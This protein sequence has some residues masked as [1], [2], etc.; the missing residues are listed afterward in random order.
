MWKF[1]RNQYI[2]FVFILL[3]SFFQTGICSGAFTIDDEKKL[4]KEF[5]DKLVKHHLLL[6]NKRAN[7]Y[8]TKIGNL[9]LEGN[10]QVPFNFRF[11]IVNNSAINAFATPGGYIY[12]NKGLINAV[13]NEG[14]LAG[15]IAHEIAHANARHVASIIEKSQKLNIATL[16]AVLAGAFLGGGGEA[17]A[18]IATLSLAGAASL[19]LKYSREHEEEADRLGIEYLTSAGYYPAAMVDFLKIIKKYEFISKS[20]PSYLLTHPGTDERIFYLESLI[21]TQYRQGGLKNIIGNLGRIQALLI[22]DGDDLNTRYKQLKESTSKDPGNVDLLYALALVEDKLGKTTEALNSYQK[23]LS[24]APRDEDVLKSLGLIN[25]KMGKTEQA[26]DYL[27]RA[28]AS[29]PYNDEVILALGKAYDA[30]GK[31]DK[32]LDCFLKLENKI[33]DD[34]DIHYYI[35]MTYGKLN[36]LGESHYNFGLYF[37]NIKKKDT[38][39]FHFKKALDYF[40]E[41]SD[42]SANIKKTIDALK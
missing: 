7:E 6:E 14:E 40:P 26:R 36:I 22:I 18:A 23:A 12:I 9:I 35:A 3:I 27:L 39:L 30:L 37:K 33:L 1:S 28:R 38:A 15:V 13:G 17:T 11:S 32:A 41:N 25:L 29:N 31:H 5:Y 10:K 20:I 2:S 8:I 19:S 4:G 34:V 42:R 21:L 16:A 24:L